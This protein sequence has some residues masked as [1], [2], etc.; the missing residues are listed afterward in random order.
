L[1]NAK[2]K[3]RNRIEFSESLC[4]L[5]NK[6]DLVKLTWNRGD[7]SG[8]NLIDEQHKNLLESGNKLIT[9]L[10]NKES[11]EICTNYLDKL[12][13]DIKIHFKDEEEIFLKTK[14]P[15]AESHIISHE[16]LIKKAESLRNKK[17][18]IGL[19]LGEVVSFIIYEVIAQHLAIEDK[20]YF[21][22]ISEGIESTH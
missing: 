7:E 10:I 3:G 8:N 11:N 17:Y 1:Y 12:I 13:K 15:E 2:E 4:K 5:E 6:T 18:P 21:P 19:N 20:G 9:A 22:Y 14:Y 16:N